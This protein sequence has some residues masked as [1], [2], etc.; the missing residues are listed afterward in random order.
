M[1]DIE[2]VDNTNA[3]AFVNPDLI[4]QV[5]DN[6]RKKHKKVS[7]KETNKS[8]VKQKA[9][10]DYV[11]FPYMRNEV[12]ENYPLWSLVNLKFYP[13]FINT[14][15]VM[16]QGELQ[17]ME[18]GVVRR[19]CH[20][21]AHRI[22][23]KQGAS[24]TPENIVDL[25]NDVKSAVTDLL[26]KCFN[27][28]LSISDDIYKNITIEAATEEQI[29]YLKKIISFVDEPKLR[30]KFKSILE[31]SYNEGKINSTTFNSFSTS[32]KNQASKFVS[33]KETFGNL[34]FESFSNME[35]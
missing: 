29:L 28:Y 22:Q 14:G 1:N 3:L 7:S 34:T 27:T 2:R 5:E 15:W 10:M 30:D 12:D 16:V 18:E 17:W 9:G 6:I 23:F 33:D 26:K 25:G 32:L 20:A 24:R 11:D 8:H 19:G 4:K 21:A 31:T 13:E 35:I